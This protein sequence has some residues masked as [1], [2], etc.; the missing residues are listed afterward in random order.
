[1]QE[2]GEEHYDE[3]DMEHPLAERLQSWNNNHQQPITIIFNT[4]M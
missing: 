2:K 4:I 3:I 1:M